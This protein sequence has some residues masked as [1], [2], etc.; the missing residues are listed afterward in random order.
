MRQQTWSF[1]E[2][3]KLEHVRSPRNRVRISPNLI[4]HSTAMSINSGNDACFLTNQKT[5]LRNQCEKTTKTHGADLIAKD[6]VVPS[7]ASHELHDRSSDETTRT[8]SA[9]KNLVRSLCNDNSRRETAW[10]TRRHT[11]LSTRAKSRGNVDLKLRSLPLV[12]YAP[13]ES[14]YML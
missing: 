8:T 6:E 7:P 11:S 9:G 10:P 1:Q 3:T 12:D 4:V 13:G 14:T 5:T 2:L